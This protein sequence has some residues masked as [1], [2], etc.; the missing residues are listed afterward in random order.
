MNKVKPDPLERD[1]ERA[2]Q[3]TAQRFEF[4]MLSKRYHCDV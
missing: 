3:R 4:E 1:K 2:L